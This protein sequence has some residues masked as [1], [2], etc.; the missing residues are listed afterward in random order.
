MAQ[1]RV[2]TFNVASAIATEDDGDNA[3]KRRAPLNVATIKRH[4]PEVIGF[5]QCDDGN[6]ATYYADLAD[7]SYVLGPAADG[8]DPYSYNAIAYDPDRVNLLD[9][10]G[11]FLS[12]TPETW[13]L[14]WDA[15]DVRALTWAR[16]RARGDGAEFVHLNTHLDHI[17]ERARVESVKLLLRRLPDLRGADLPVVLTGDFNCNPWTPGYRVHVE[18]TF[19]D[20]SYH[21]LRAHGFADS[22]LAVG[23]EDSVASFTFHGFEGPRCWAAQHHVA[24]RIDWILTLDGARPVRPR[25]CFIARDEAPPVFP[26]DHYP[27]VADIEL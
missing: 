1:L 10:G 6:L 3:W 13:A 16:F 19:T 15:A 21:I 27:V 14:G 18:S 24:G 7:Y 4:A 26:S 11:F 23:G 25:N 17:G 8:P 22:F 2:M 9:Q 20:V 5:Q 12:E